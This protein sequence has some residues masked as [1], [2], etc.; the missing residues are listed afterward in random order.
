MDGSADDDDDD[1][2]VNKGTNGTNSDPKRRHDPG[3]S[4]SQDKDWIFEERPMVD[5][6]LKEAQVGSDISIPCMRFQNN[7]D[8]S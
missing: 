7:P 2:R 8:L 5:P 4:E 3:P 1:N 6:K